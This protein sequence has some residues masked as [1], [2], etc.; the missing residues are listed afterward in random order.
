MVGISGALFGPVIIDLWKVMKECRSF[1]ATCLTVS[2]LVVGGPVDSHSRIFLVA[3]GFIHEPRMA[4]MG[5]W[6]R[7]IYISIFCYRFLATRRLPA[8]LDVYLGI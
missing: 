2:W 4:T 6:A 7:A 1:F 3:T 5:L 8:A